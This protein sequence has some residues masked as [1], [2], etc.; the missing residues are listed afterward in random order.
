MLTV[1]KDQVAAF[2]IN[3]H[4]FQSSSL[5]HLEAVED[6]FR[7]LRLIQYDPLNPCGRNVDLV[8]QSRLNSYHVNGFIPW[9]YKKAQAID[10]YDKQLCVLPIEDWGYLHYFIDRMSPVRRQFIQDHR[11]QL[12]D[13]LLYIADNGPV[14]T[15]ILKDGR[16]VDIGWYDPTSWSKTALESLWRLGEVVS[17]RQ[18][19][20]RKMYDIP[21]RVYGYAM[22]ERPSL[23]DHVSRRLAS[24]GLLPLS[25]G[26]TGW[27]GTGTGRVIG[28][29]VK[30][31][32]QSG[33]LSEV[34]VEGSK[35]KYVVRLQD[36]PLLE[37]PLQ[38][39]DAVSFLAP[40]DN[41]L[42]DR[43]LIYDIFG[44]FY[45]WEVYTPEHKRTY[46]Y[47]CLPILK[48]HSLVGRIEPALFHNS[49]FI[50]GLWWEDGGKMDLADLEEPIDKFRRY[51]KASSVIWSV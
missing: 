18:E 24:T 41:F 23:S 11:E 50:K 5:P 46:G 38:T 33:A 31:M 16:K 42:W 37:S 25:G 39:T 26:G 20:G 47:Y 27:L 6:V 13:L 10:G 29:H 7:H 17:L 22:P 2:L 30:A 15:D 3:H 45:R 35:T 49:L 14:P 40:L 8:L 4:R 1:T 12:N 32:V 34:S 43:Q 44:F 48:G 21:Q 19:S 9:A 28:N 36:R 51:L